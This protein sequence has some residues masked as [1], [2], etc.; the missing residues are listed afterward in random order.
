MTDQELEIHNRQYLQQELQKALSRIE[1]LENKVEIITFSL[2]DFFSKSDKKKLALEI[3][4]GKLPELFSKIIDIICKDNFTTYH[5]LVNEKNRLDNQTARHIIHY[6][7]HKYFIERNK[8]RMRLKLKLSLELVGII[9]QR[10]HCA[11]LW[12]LGKISNFCE[13]D[14]KFKQKFEETVQKCEQE[15]IKDIELKC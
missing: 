14:H 4:N 12:S 9:T 5:S 10:S 11:V 2:D 7:F 3:V 13:T 8:Y 1:E 6:V 15:I